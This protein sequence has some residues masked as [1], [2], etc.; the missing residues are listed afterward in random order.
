MH[1]IDRTMGRTNLEAYEFEGED[2]GGYEAESEQMLNEEE[3]EE[4][5]SELLS[6]TNEQELEQFLGNIFKTVTGAVGNFARSPAGQQVGGILK[7][8]AHK[9]IPLAGQ[10]VGNWVAPG[11]GGQ[12]G[13]Q[14]ASGVGSMFGLELEGMS[15][16]DRDFEVAK[17]FVRLAA[18]AAQAAA[19]AP[20]GIRPGADRTTGGGA[21]G[22]EVRA[23]P[24]RAG[25][26]RRRR[27]HQRIVGEEPG[28][29]GAQGQ[30]DWSSTESDHGAGAIRLLE[31]GARGPRSALPPGARQVVRSPGDH[32]SGRQPERRGAVGHRALPHG[33][34]ALATESHRG[35]H[36]LDQTARPPRGDG[37]RSPPP[38]HAAAPALQYRAV[39]R[40]HLQRGA[41][42]AQRGRC[43]RLAGRPGRRLARRAGAARSTSTPRR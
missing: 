19:H 42:P 21:G 41:Q 24:A 28:P 10:A 25:G 33:P 17:Q 5:A 29:L 20:P 27:G 40:R 2:E 7:N 37:G 26:R 6:V 32:G 30:Q 16:E 43:R 12:I 34:Q 3:L 22:A 1:D 4:V 36:R 38:L 31:P 8:I 39:A 14:L 18:D 11:V 15:H 35:L 23:R 13:G 9:A